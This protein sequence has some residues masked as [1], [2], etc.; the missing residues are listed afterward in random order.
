MLLSYFDATQ[1]EAGVDE[2]GRGCLAGVVVA[3]AVVLPKDF[4]HG[5]LTDSKQ[6]SAKQRQIIAEEIKKEALDYAIAEVSP[7]EIDQ[8]NIL[9]ASFLAMHRAIAQLKTQVELLLIDGNRF[10]P[11]P[12]KKHQCIIK[13]DSKYLSIAA[14]SV[15]AKTYRDALMTDLAQQYPMYSWEKNAG[16]PT[17]AH[18]KAIET[19][20]V[21]PYHRMT[22]KL[23]KDKENTLF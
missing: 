1:T 3:A 22:F 7:A 14:A 2:V 8:I 9:N 18:R 11:Y 23:L 15:L 21:S 6:L 4:K 5:L 13:G 20:G 10:K 17:I 19:Y 12:E 16:Y